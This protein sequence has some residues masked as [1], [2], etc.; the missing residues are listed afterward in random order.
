MGGL[1]LDK[2]CE[3]GSIHRGSAFEGGFGFFYTLNGWR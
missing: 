3:E 1:L 2:P